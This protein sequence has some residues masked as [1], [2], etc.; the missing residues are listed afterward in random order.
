MSHIR[1]V[2][3]TTVTLF[4]CVAQFDN[5]DADIIVVPGLGVLIGPNPNC[6]DI[7]Y[8]GVD[9]DLGDSPE[10]AA[11]A[12]LE[13]YIPLRMAELARRAAAPT[14]SVDPVTPTTADG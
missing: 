7:Y 12:A 5:D 1:N 9:V 11:Y 2:S 4:S 13:R 6:L 3:T 10:A 14:S 8:E